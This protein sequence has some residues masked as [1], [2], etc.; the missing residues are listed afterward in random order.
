VRHHRSKGN[1]N[2]R[3]SEFSQRGRT[4]RLGAKEVEEFGI[5]IP[6][7]NWMRFMAMMLLQKM[8]DL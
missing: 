1:E 7:C 4:K 8:N 3:A 6:C 5:D 2:R